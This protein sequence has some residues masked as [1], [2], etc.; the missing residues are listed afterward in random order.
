MKLG[1]LFCPLNGT[2]AKYGASVSRS[3]LSIGISMTDNCKSFAVSYVTIPD[4]EKYTPNSTN[5]FVHFL[6][7]VQECKIIEEGLL[8]STS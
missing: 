8:N 1:L 3:N 4:I 7:P 6:P 5:R 2:G